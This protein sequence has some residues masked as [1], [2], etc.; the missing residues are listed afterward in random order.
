MEGSWT[1]G[2]WN[3]MSRDA[4]VNIG[5]HRQQPSPELYGAKHHYTVDRDS[6]PLHC[7]EPVRYA[8]V[9]HP[10]WPNGK[11]KTWEM[12]GPLIARD[13]RIDEFRLLLQPMAKKRK[14][15]EKYVRFM[16]WDVDS[17]LPTAIIEHRTYLGT[18][19][20]LPTY[21]PRE[22]GRSGFY[23]DHVDNTSPCYLINSFRQLSDA[24][25]YSNLK[26]PPRKRCQ[27]LQSLQ[28]PMNP[29]LPASTGLWK[30]NQRA[31]LRKA[32]T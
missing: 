20:Y 25:L 21:L 12:K 19:S 9:R 2:R 1:P 8:R 29:P 15:F 5:Q 16:F 17:C 31:A 14:R 13:V 7:L 24:K 23:I 22:V 26:S 10:S 18:L 28:F 4:P 30:P 3:A 6:E 11:P 27:L 32:R